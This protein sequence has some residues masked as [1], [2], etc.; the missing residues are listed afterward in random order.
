MIRRFVGASEYLCGLCE[1]FG[2]GFRGF[3]DT[4]VYESG[5]EVKKACLG[6]KLAYTIPCGTLK[7]DSCCGAPVLR[8]RWR[9]KI[10]GAG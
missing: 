4:L 5:V 3:K 9:F 10:I 6:I 8:Q 2:V 7:R 1:C